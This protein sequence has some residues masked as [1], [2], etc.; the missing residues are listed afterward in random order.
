MDDF[1]SVNLFDSSYSMNR[2]TILENL[3]H[4]NEELKV[5][6]VKGKIALVDGAVM[7]LVLK[8]RES[9]HDIDAIFEPKSIVYECIEKTAL[10]RNLPKDW[11]NDSVKGFMSRD[12]EFQPHLELSNLDVLI[13]TPEY[14]LAMKCLSSR[15]ESETELEDIRNL[16][17]HLGIDTYE[18]VEKIMLKYY[19]ITRFQIKT[20]YII[21]E[22]IVELHS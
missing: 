14:M 4:L 20:K 8:T 2:E 7:C 21:Q 16:I 12:A 1:P 17:Q 19:P 9:T 10:K 18:D 22:I 15:A 6:D 3:M 5:K 13:A 11:L